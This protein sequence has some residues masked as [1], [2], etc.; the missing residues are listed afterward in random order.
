MARPPYVT[1]LIVREAGFLPL[2]MTAENAFSQDLGNGGYRGG[3]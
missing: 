3:A 1:H 2:T